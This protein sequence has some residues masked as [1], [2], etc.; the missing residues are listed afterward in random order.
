MRREVRE[1]VQGGYRMLEKGV[2][3]RSRGNKRG[4]ITGVSKLSLSLDH[5]DLRCTNCV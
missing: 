1:G 4:L 3:E 5:T 2:R